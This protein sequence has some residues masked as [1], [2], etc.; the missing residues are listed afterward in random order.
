MTVCLTCEE[1]ARKSANTKKEEETPEGEN[2]NESEVLRGKSYPNDTSEKATGREVNAKV[3]ID[4]IIV[5]RRKTVICSNTSKKY[6]RAK[7]QKIS[8]LG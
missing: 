6:T 3:N 8:S 7:N 1:E 2:D 5:K 4:T